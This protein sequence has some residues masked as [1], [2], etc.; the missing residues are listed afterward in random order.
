MTLLFVG[1]PLDA[2]PTLG[3]PEPTVSRDL[4]EMRIALPAGGVAVLEITSSEAEAE[5][6]FERRLRT[7]ATHWPTASVDLS[8]FDRAAGDGG[9]ILLVR[10]RNA[11]LYVRDLGNDADAI[12]SG[13][14]GALTTDAARC[15]GDVCFTSSAARTRP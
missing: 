10:E 12:A 7:S 15:A 9:A 8:S 13:L 5:M 14:L 11:V 4:P 2:L 3:L 1:L 6:A